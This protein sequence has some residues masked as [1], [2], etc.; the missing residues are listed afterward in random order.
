MM[1]PAGKDAAMAL[2]TTVELL[3][4]GSV[5][6]DD[7]EAQWSSTLINFGYCTSRI[8]A[9]VHADAYSGD[10]KAFIE[11]DD[12]HLPAN[13]LE[14]LSIKLYWVCGI[15]MRNFD[16]ELGI[17]T[18]DMETLLGRMFYRSDAERVLRKFRASITAHQQATKPASVA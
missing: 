18:I 3:D 16:C 5:G 17:A 2:W 13:L 10:A 8:Q 12:F 1:Q 4:N 6:E 11:R 9:N 14:A 7:G 15:H